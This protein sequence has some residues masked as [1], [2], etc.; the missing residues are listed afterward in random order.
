MARH[1][2]QFALLLSIIV[3]R[4]RRVGPLIALTVVGTTRRTGLIA[5]ALLIALSVPLRAQEQPPELEA[6]HKRGLQ[7]YQAGKFA[8]AIPVVE[9]YIAVAAAKFGE[10]HPLY[11]G[12]LGGLGVLYHKLGRMGEA[13]PLLKRALTITEK[14]LGPVHLEVADALNDLAEL[15]QKQGRLSEAES[16]LS[17]SAEHC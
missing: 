9:E 17:A 4:A 16:A 13:E 2:A 10:E 14:A 12:G 8:E 15:Y 6:I 1:F 11:A 5:I 7:L 3:D